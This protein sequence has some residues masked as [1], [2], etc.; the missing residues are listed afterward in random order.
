MPA[1]ASCSR[2]T[3]CILFRNSFHTSWPRVASHPPSTHSPRSLRHWKHSGTARRQTCAQPTKYEYNI[4]SPRKNKDE[5][6]FGQGRLC[7]MIADTQS[8]IM[9]AN[10]AHQTVKSQTC[11]CNYRNLMQEST[12]TINVQTTTGWNPFPIRPSGTLSKLNSG[13]PIAAARLLR[14]DYPAALAISF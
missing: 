10:V 4:S 14:T 1:Y 9:A 5:T 2:Y 13:A 6:I 7:D 12:T 3:V 11:G 8:S